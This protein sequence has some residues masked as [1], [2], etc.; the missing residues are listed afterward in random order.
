LSPCPSVSLSLCPFVPKGSSVSN[1]PS[2]RVTFIDEGPYH[3]DK[4]SRTNYLFSFLIVYN[5]LLCRVNRF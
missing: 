1:A 5:A 4:K 3:P 2:S